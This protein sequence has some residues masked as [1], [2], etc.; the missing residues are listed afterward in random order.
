MERPFT[1]SILIFIV[2]SVVLHC[3]VFFICFL[4]LHASI[5]FFT[6]GALPFLYLE[7]KPLPPSDKIRA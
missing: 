6:D 7:S 2:R 1:W 5:V 3:I 4:Y